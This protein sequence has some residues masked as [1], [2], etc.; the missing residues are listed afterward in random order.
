[1]PLL[2]LGITMVHCCLPVERRNVQQKKPD[3]E[4]NRDSPKFR[5]RA[6]LSSPGKSN[7]VSSL[8]CRMLLQTS[9]ELLSGLYLS[10]YI[11]LINRVILSSIVIRFFRPVMYIN[12]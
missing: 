1:M 6:V 7:H 4:G 12:S 11:F 5:P 10:S 2:N 9:T 8:H 3:Y